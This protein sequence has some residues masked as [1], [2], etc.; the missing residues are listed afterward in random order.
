MITLF[1]KPYGVTPSHPYRD[2]QRSLQGTM[3]GWRGV[4]FSMSSGREAYD[5]ELT[6]IA[7]GL[8]L[9]S[10]RGERGQDFTLLTDSQAA[11]RRMASDAPRPGQEIAIGAIGL[12]QR[13]IDQG[14]TVT[15]DRP[16]L[17]REWREKSRQISE[18]R[19]R[20]PSAPPRGAPS[21]DTVWL[22]EKN[23][24]RAGHPAVAKRHRRPR[25]R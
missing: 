4:G 7:Y 18:R 11:M 10:R 14:N 9:L 15:S 16:R 5:A 21:G 2:R 12:A 19:K 25:R 6:A 1:R 24:N 13:L 17:T 8:L 20:R 3:S 23:G 22:L